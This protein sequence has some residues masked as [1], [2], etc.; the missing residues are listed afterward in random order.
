MSSKQTF[1]RT[2]SSSLL[3][4]VTLGSI[5]GG[6]GNGVLM[7]LIR[8]VQNACYEVCYEYALAAALGMTRPYISLP[9]LVT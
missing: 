5:E 3:N 7:T 2:F 1:E 9:V 4:A 8:Y 6:G